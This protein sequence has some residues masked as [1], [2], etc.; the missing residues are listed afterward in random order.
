MNDHSDLLIR[1]IKDS[2][3]S[4]QTP[5]KNPIEG[6]M[7]GYIMKSCIEYL[8]ISS[9]IKYRLYSKEM[10]WTVSQLNM[11]FQRKISSLDW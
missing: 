8:K 3:I 4:E 7:E 5:K 6:S 9:L 1:Y 11:K 2:G 10:P